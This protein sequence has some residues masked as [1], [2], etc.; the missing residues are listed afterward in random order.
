MSILNKIIKKD[1]EE[2]KASVGKEGKKSVVRKAT[3]KPAVVKREKSGVIPI[4]FFEIIERPYISEK[5]F[6]S[7]ELGQYVFVVSASSNKSEIKKAVEKFYKVSVESVNIT[8]AHSKPKRYKGIENTRSGFKKAVVTLKK[9][10]S[11]D[12]MEGA[13]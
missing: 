3:P 5:A 11:I 10:S 2:V 8:K 12:V 6:S 7:N 4:H 9:G 1:E 13:K